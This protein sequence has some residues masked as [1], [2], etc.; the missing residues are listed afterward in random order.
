VKDNKLQHGALIVA[1]DIPKNNFAER[2]YYLKV[3][4]RASFSFALVSVAAALEMR[5]D[6]IEKARVVLGSV[7]AVP[8]PGGRVA[9]CVVYV[10][11]AAHAGA[12]TPGG[13]RATVYTPGAAQAEVMS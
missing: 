9:R 1:I 2:S 12:Y 4:D 10:P 6:T 11:G 5:G 3:R 8:A 7:V 13:K